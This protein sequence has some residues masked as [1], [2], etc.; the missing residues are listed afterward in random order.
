MIRN[1]DIQNIRAIAFDFD[2]VILDS[3]RLKANLFIDAYDEPIT[4][5]QVD[6]IF[7]YQ[8]QHGGVGRVKKFE[9]FEKNVFGRRVDP[10]KV[11]RLA[12]RYSHLL[13]QR[14]TE[15]RELPGA[16][17][18]LDRAFA[19]RSLHLVSGT[20][21]ED[22]VK[23]VADRGLTKYFVWIMGAPM[24]KLEAFRAIATAANLQPQQVLA[25]GDSITEYAAAAA[26]G[27]PFVGIVEEG[28]ANPFPNTV[29]V[30]QDLAGLNADWE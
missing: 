5:S 29:L 11:R 21:H 8:S 28:Q 1:L 20:S 27:M 25:I 26:F 12:S 22:L 3:V 15:C 17:A 2:G 19:S 24:G 23:I 10:E 13:M 14:V 7:A 16:R 4:P 9:Y 18:F 30:Y 6:A